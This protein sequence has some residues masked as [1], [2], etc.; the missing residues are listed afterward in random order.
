MD[1]KKYMTQEPKLLT[2]AAMARIDRLYKLI[3]GLEGIRKTVSNIPEE[4]TS[5]A[6]DAAYEAIE[7]AFIAGISAEQLGIQEEVEKR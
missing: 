1:V 5:E 7:R 6:L 2:E 4:N 3:E